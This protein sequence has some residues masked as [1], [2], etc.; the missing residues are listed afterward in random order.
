MAALGL[1]FGLLLIVKIGR[2]RALIPTSSNLGII[3]ILSGIF[4]AKI[5]MVLVDF[6]YYAAVSE[7]QRRLPRPVAAIGFDVG[8]A[9]VSGK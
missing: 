7:L 4:G 6:T 5:L 1:I 9:C 2:N 8:R 3:A